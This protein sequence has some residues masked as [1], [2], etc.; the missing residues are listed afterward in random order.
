MIQSS[1]ATHR[2]RGLPMT[3]W[4]RAAIG[5]A[6]LVLITTTTA[7]AQSARER[8][9]SVRTV[10]CTFVLNAVGTWKTGAPQADVKTTQLAVK[11]DE[12]NADDGT[13]RV[14]GMFGP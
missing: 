1:H 2:S 13:A 6:T 9:A 3:A 4:K 12:V 11:F 10:D 14:V 7:S 8:L 5:I